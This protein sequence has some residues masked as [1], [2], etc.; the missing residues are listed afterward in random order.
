MSLSEDLESEF[1]HVYLCFC[2]VCRGTRVLVLVLVLVRFCDGPGLEPQEHGVQQSAGIASTMKD[3]LPANALRSQG[4]IAS[5][6]RCVTSPPWRQVTLWL[7]QCCHARL[8]V[9]VYALAS[10]CVLSHDRSH[11]YRTAFAGS[12]PLS[13]LPTTPT[14]TDLRPFGFDEWLTPAVG[15]GGDSTGRD[16]DVDTTVARACDW[17]HAPAPASPT[18]SER[19]TRTPR[20][21]VVLLGHCTWQPPMWNTSLPPLRD[22]HAAS[23]AGATATG[24]GDA[25][26]ADV[27]GAGAGALLALPRHNTPID[28]AAVPGIV[29]PAWQAWCRR[30]FRSSNGGVPHLDAGDG[31][32]EVAWWDHE[33]EDLVEC[34]QHAVETL[35][36]ALSRSSV[37]R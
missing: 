12:W 8:F 5:R 1:H 17:L 32:E 7:T 35:H 10:F 11:G 25:D 16:D 18:A 26:A 36:A 4:T 14:T 29:Y 31:V 37:V 2:V 13:P 22:P 6:L 34:V 15:S 20:F 27:T 24:T 28:L 19:S 3:V 21:I 30:M 23:H 33:R 9:V